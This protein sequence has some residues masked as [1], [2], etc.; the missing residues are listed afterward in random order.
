LSF[1][2][3]AVRRKRNV[4]TKEHWESEV[5]GKSIHYPKGRRPKWGTTIVGKSSPRKPLIIWQIIQ[6]ARG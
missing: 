3:K 1:I 5:G 4:H 6:I 2:L